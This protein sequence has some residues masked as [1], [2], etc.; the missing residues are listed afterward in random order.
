[1]KRQLVRNTYKFEKKAPGRL[2][3]NLNI[4][5]LTLS[6]P[7]VTVFGRIAVHNSA[8][9]LI[10]GR[11]DANENNMGL[12]TWKGAK[13]RRVDITVAKNYLT[14]KELKSLNRIVT[15]YLD[16]AEEQAGNINCP[17]FV[18]EM[19]DSVCRIELESLYH[20]VSLVLKNGVGACEC[21]NVSV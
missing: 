21:A 3:E 12:T 4:M 16:Y 10:A 20:S 13:V 1:M 5:G 6:S 17:V 11:A 9:E 8:A 19:A 7:S 2:S 14:E 15:M 18:Q